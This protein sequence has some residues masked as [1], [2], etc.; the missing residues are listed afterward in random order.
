[1]QLAASGTQRVSS[2]IV[3]VE[4]GAGETGAA[5]SQVLSS[6]RALTGESQRLKSEMGRFLG[7]VRS[8]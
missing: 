7:S 4:R 5:S 3:E 1:V 8:A 2:S 6:A